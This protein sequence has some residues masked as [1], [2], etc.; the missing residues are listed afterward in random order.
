MIITNR[1]GQNAVIK[2]TIAIPQTGTFN[3]RV[4]AVLQQAM[5]ELNN[6]WAGVHV[7]DADLDSQTAAFL[8]DIAARRANKVTVDLS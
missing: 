3:D 2:I 8:T 7:V 1:V 5:L 4:D 6:Y